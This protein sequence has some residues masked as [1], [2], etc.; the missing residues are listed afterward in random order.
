MNETDMKQNDYKSGDRIEFPVINDHRGNLSFIEGGRHVPFGIAR[1]YYLY[2]VPVG[3]ERGSHAHYALDQVM[4]AMSGSFDLTLDDG[5]KRWKVHL[6]RPDYGI[7]VGSM[8]WHEMENFSLG[9]VCMVLASGKYD[10][11]D[12]IRSYDD[13]LRAVGRGGQ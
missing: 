6:N 9:S 13:F 2:D 10:E 12:Y 1:V 4:I 5:R 7:Y 11:P 3:A 8:V